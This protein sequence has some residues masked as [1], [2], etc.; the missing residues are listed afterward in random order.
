MV[1][2]ALNDPDW[3]VRHDAFDTLA[4][5]LP[6][7]P[8][9]PFWSLILDMLRHEDLELRQRV[10][11]LMDHMFDDLPPEVLSRLEDMAHSPSLTVRFSP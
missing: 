6:G 10:L 3:G 8:D 1:R 5:A 4:Q 2:P 7:R 9:E 11:D